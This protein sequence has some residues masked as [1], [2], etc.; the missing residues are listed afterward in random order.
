MG[1]FDRYER[2][3]RLFTEE[4]SSWSV[5]EISETFKTSTSTVYRT[6]RELVEAGFLES[7]VDSQFRLGPAFVEFARLIRVTDPLI[8]SGAVF[9]APLVAQIDV[10]A[11]AVLAR[12]YAGRVMCVA[13]APSP[14]RDLQTSYQRGRPM[15]ILR[16]ATSK[17]IL[18]ALP[19]RRRDKVFASCGLAQGPERDRL[20]TDLDRIRKRGVSV[21]R[22]EVDPGLVGIAVPVRNAGLGIHASV[23]F[24]LSADD[25]T[26][27]R[28]RRMSALLTAH[29]R[30][31]E[32][33]MQDAYEAVEASSTKQDHH[34]Q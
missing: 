6:V 16:G 10:A 11:T 2:I 15:P 23:S 32:T 30:L 34:P 14:Q 28:E 5:A 25:V 13:E 7:A 8:R 31:I 9:L 20:L 17:A 22:G 18:A 4:K 29:A 3:L 33:Y 27:A 19:A 24:V 21:T 26:D 1:G 12:L